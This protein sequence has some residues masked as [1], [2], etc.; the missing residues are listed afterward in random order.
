VFFQR[1][2]NRPDIDPPG[3]PIRLL[4]V[5]SGNTCRSPLAEVLSRR[6]ASE[7]GLHPVEV[8]SAGTHTRPGLEASGGALRV[9]RR[10]GLSL[11]GHASTVL[12]GE[13]VEW[14][15]LIF[16]MGPGHQ[17]R[18]E[19]L[20]G[21]DKVVLLG[22]FATEENPDGDGTDG[23]HLAVPDPFGGD[24]EIYEETFL[25]LEKY[26]ELAIRRLVGGDGG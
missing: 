3:S 5:C 21:G 16:A 22:A 2:M 11:E 10:H 25:T 8:R 19:T 20:G 9:A 26:V 12:S 23:S 24:D 14:A 18:L 13:L 6:A 7:S 1:F 4:F 17:D 15:D